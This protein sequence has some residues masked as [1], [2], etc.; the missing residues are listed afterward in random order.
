MNYYTL[1]IVECCFN[2]SKPT[3]L[4][5][6]NSEPETVRESEN[7]DYKERDIFLNKFETSLRFRLVVHSLKL[8]NNDYF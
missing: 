1:K 6:L 4:K 8:F 5:N 3:I 2:L 7:Q